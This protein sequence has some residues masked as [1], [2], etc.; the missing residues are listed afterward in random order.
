MWTRWTWPPLACTSFAFALVLALIAGAP[1]C[2]NDPFIEGS[3]AAGG[4]PPEG[5]GS[6]QDPG[7]GG[8]SAAE[9]TD[10]S[11]CPAPPA[12][13]C[14]PIAACDDGVCGVAYDEGPIA[15]QKYGD[16]KITVCT[17]QGELA[18]E[19]DASDVYDDGNHC[20]LDHCVNGAPVNDALATG[21]SCE[22]GVCG[23]SPFSQQIECLECDPGDS[24]SCLLTQICVKG[25]CAPPHC[26]DNQQDSGETGLNCGGECPPC[27]SGLPCILA[28]D[29]VSGVCSGAPKKCASPACDDNVKNGKES[30]I[31]CGG[32]DCPPCDA[33][34]A[35]N[36]PADCASGVCEH[37]ICKQPSC[38]DGTAN[39]DEQGVDCG[40]PCS[41]CP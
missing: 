3:G 20:T 2:G 7:S 24:T 11:Q 22:T 37:N 5:G 15:S 4:A 14:N 6:A 40:G 8:S 32:L 31:D 36:F 9:C 35:C 27:A 16:C 39:G 10:A 19:E 17:S 1:G 30:S 29:C 23:M 26:L 28:T 21:S 25:H 38:D 33:P 18:A 41:A 34:A 13:P 12:G